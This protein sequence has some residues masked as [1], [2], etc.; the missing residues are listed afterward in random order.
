MIYQSNANTMG[1]RKDISDIT[2]GPSMNLGAGTPDPKDRRKALRFQK[3]SESKRSTRTWL[4][5]VRRAQARERVHT[6]Y[7]SAAIDDPD[8]SD[9]RLSASP[10]L[11][12]PPLLRPSALLSAVQATPPAF[13]AVHDGGYTASDEH[14]AADDG[15]DTDRD[16]DV[17]GGDE[18][19]HD[20]HDDGQHG[21]DGDGMQD[22]AA[23]GGDS[24]SSSSSSSS[25]DDDMDNDEREDDNEREEDDNEREE[26]DNE[27]ED[28]N[29]S[30]SP[31]A[32]DGIAQEENDHEIPPP[33]PLV[34]TEPSSPI[35][36]LPPLE[37]TNRWRP[38]RP[39]TPGP[40]PLR[41]ESIVGVHVQEPF[42]EDEGDVVDLDAPPDPEPATVVSEAQLA[43]AEEF[44]RQALSPSAR[45]DT[46]TEP[47]T[48]VVETKPLEDFEDEQVATRT[49]AREIFGDPD[50][51]DSDG[52]LGL[53]LKTNGADATH[54]EVE[55]L[56]KSRR[57]P[58][59]PAEAPEERK[60]VAQVRL[61]SY[62]H[63]STASSLSLLFP[64]S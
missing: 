9:A 11:V 47:A 39:P 41:D 43:E 23:D 3:E 64:P 20:N 15:G 6:P 28:D 38:P 14:M 30:T 18:G 1:E 36:I 57:S 52:E 16:E 56:S 55:V 35:Q 59:P 4:E 33:A 44:I 42:G 54:D 25:D 63:P 26:D 8:D 5:E 53:G 12:L 62:Y 37:R 17:D 32:G 48:P 50:D 46:P 24:S 58:S 2:A 40:H 19:E 51:P 60:E 31:Q 21:D 10:P 29:E 13:V 49:D 45:C 27:R 7:P 34:P 22:D 61:L